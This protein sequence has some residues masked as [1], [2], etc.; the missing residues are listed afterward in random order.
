MQ[1]NMCVYTLVNETQWLLCAKGI[2]KE[3]SM[4]VLSV[5]DI[6]DN[7]RKLE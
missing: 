3:H 5:N 4:S 7:S 1:N 2:T 6:N